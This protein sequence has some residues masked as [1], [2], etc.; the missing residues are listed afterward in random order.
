MGGV[1]LE[2]LNPSVMHWERR[3]VNFELMATEFYAPPTASFS[4]FTVAAFHDMGFYRLSSLA[5]SYVEPY[6]WGEGRGCAFV[7]ECSEA[8]W[9]GGVWCSGNYGTG[10]D[11]TWAAACGNGVL[12]PALQIPPYLH[13]PSGKEGSLGGWDPYADYCPYAGLAAESV[14][15]TQCA[16]PRTSNAVDRRLSNLSGVGTRAVFSNLTSLYGVPAGGLFST[17]PRCMQLL[18]VNT[19]ALRFRAGDSYY[20]CAPFPSTTELTPPYTT[21][22]VASGRRQYTISSYTF[23]GLVQCPDASLACATGT[24]A[25]DLL[26]GGTRYFSEKAMPRLVNITP[27][28]GS[29]AGGTV[30]LVSVANVPG[31]LDMDCRGLVIGG[32]PTD[33]GSYRFVSYSPSPTDGL[34]RHDRS[35]ECVESVSWRPEF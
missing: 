13:F 25:A 12:P 16:A 14:V 11:L 8:T 22:T 4:K 28:S 17:P 34:Q 7:A 2:E 31:D 24:A 3:Q 32:Q 23:Y 20:P 10:F 1:L 6:E 9:S 33:I 27:S 29:L 26:M 30:L 19:T 5:A 18:C 35:A 21:S 15:V